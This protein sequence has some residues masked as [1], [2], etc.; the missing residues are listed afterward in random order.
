MAKNVTTLFICLWAFYFNNVFTLKAIIGEDIPHMA[1]DG[2]LS[3]A[4]SVNALASIAYSI[5]G[6]TMT[7]YSGINA[8]LDSLLKDLRI[9]ESNYLAVFTASPQSTEE[10]KSCQWE[11]PGLERR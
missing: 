7:Q 10:V 8:V 6:R 5:Y 4:L 11:P 1:C 2:N 9:M 3:S